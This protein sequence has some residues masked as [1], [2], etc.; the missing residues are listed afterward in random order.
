MRF[1]KFA[2]T[3]GGRVLAVV[4]VTLSLVHSPLPQ[5]DFHNTR[6]HHGPGEVCERHDHLL[7]WH[8]GEARA[9]DVEV[10]HWHWPLLTSDAGAPAP[11]GAGPAV[12]AHDFDGAARPWDV[13]PQVTAPTTPRPDLRP[14]SGPPPPAFAPAAPETWPALVGRSPLPPGDLLARRASLTSLLHRWVC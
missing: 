5:P 9:D 11:E 14:A 10:L 1:R 13:S 7:R 12:H 8:P 4:F 2:Q 6:H 3:R